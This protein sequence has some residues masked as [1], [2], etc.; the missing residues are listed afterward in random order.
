MKWYLIILILA[1]MGCSSQ[2]TDYAKIV[3]D[4]VG[5]TIVYPDSIETLDGIIF[6]RP[7]TDYTILSYYDATGCTSCRMKLSKW[8]KLLKEIDSLKNDVTISLILVAE[9]TKP[10][11]IDIIAQQNKFHHTILMDSNNE[12]AKINHIPEDTELQCFLLNKENE[13]ILLGNPLDNPA[14]WKLYTSE[15][16]GR[17]IET[18]GI[19]TYYHDFGRIDPNITVSHIFRL[20]NTSNDTLRFEGLYSSCECTKGKISKQTIPPNEDYQVEL[21]FKDT[22]HGYFTRSVTIEFK[23]SQ[24]IAFEINGLIR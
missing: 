11:H 16:S 24:E 21:S 17:K 15:I 14:I 1:L 5:K 10:K 4:M 19:K 22:T 8:N 20:I 12:F 6:E 2:E 23:N 18:E 9:T 13:I 3:Q 7:L